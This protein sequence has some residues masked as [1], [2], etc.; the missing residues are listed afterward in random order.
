MELQ[1]KQK[2]SENSSELEEKL[3]GTKIKQRQVR[4]RRDQ[5]RD[6]QMD[7]MINTPTIGILDKELRGVA[8]D[9]Q[10]KSLTKNR[11]DRRNLH[12]E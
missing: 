3:R 8:A 10:T 4:S 6:E 11:D 2:L 5:I 7:L 1:P 9:E 12:E